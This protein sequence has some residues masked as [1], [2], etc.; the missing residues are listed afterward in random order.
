M[1][2]TRFALFLEVL[3]TPL[4]HLLP[5]GAPLGS[6]QHELR[7]ENGREP[8][9][10]SIWYDT[11]LESLEEVRGITEKPVKAVKLQNG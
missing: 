2:E 9:S 11:L 1:A 4:C 7:V 3:W 8:G 10:K 6:S 5:F